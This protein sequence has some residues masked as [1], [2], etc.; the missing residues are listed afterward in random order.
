MKFS[1]FSETSWTW[2][3]LSQ[4]FFD[5]TTKGSLYMKWYHGFLAGDHN[6]LCLFERLLRTSLS[7]WNSLRQKLFLFSYLKPMQNNHHS[8][9]IWNLACT[10]STAFVYSSSCPLNL[11][12]EISK[13]YLHYTAYISVRTLSALHTNTCNTEKKAAWTRGLWGNSVKLFHT[14]YRTKISEMSNQ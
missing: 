4:L 10:L 5:Y 7:E 3:K 1:S 11:R 8:I 12:W 9:Q 13:L 6:L 14:Q 2:T